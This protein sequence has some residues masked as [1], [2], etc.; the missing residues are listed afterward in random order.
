[1]TGY[2]K[3]TIDAFT[4]GYRDGDAIKNALAKALNIEL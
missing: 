1:M 2:R 3:S 4:S